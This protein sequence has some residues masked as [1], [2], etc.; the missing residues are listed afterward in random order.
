MNDIDITID[1]PAKT[2]LD[3]S[4]KGGFIYETFTFPGRSYLWVKYMW[5]GSGFDAVSGSAR[6]ASSHAVTI[7]YSLVFWAVV[8]G[9]AYIWAT[10]ALDK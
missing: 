7:I 1:K 2:R 5:P 9:A 6:Q 4:T 3:G 10:G 8:S